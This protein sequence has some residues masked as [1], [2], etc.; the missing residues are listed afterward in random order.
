MSDVSMIDLPDE[1]EEDNGGD[2]TVA[3]LSGA[4]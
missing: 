4:W 1:D 3:P 2:G